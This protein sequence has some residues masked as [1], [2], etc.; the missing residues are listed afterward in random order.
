VLLKPII[1]KGIENY[2]FFTKP[3]GTAKVIYGNEDPDG[4]TRPSH[5]TGMKSLTNP[6]IPHART[7]VRQGS[8]ARQF[9]DLS[10]S[11]PHRS[12]ILGTGTRFVGGL[13]QCPGLVRAAGVG[14]VHPRSGTFFRA[15]MVCTV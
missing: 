9:L 7:S 2:L 4:H 8:I 5:I 15:R 10:A 3:S 14:V 1:D 11:P 13:P 6:H 12:H